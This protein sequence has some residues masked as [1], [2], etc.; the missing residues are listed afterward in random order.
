MFF[1]KQYIHISDVKYLNTRAKVE[2]FFFNTAIN[3]FIK[4]FIVIIEICNFKLKDFKY[5]KTILNAIC[6]LSHK[7]FGIDATRCFQVSISRYLV[8]NPN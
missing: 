6:F 5:I 2:L 4:D 8:N 1:A 7:A 3:F